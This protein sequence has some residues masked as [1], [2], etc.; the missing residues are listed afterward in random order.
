MW[1][2]DYEFDVYSHPLVV[3]DA[4]WVTDLQ[5]KLSYLPQFQ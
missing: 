5:S 4:L 3:I 2:V 1:L